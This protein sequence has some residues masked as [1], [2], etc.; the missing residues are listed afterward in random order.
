M[1][2]TIYT[3]KR[4]ETRK[5]IDSVFMENFRSFGEADLTVKEI[6]EKA[7]I[8][9]STF[10]AYYKD[11]A[12]MKEQIESRLID[13]IKQRIA[14]VYDRFPDRPEMIMLEIMAFNRENEFLPMLLISAGSSFVYRVGR[15]VAEIVTGTNVR[16]EEAREKIAMLFTYHFAGLS[17]VLRQMRETG[18]P[19]EE[20]YESMAQTVAETILPV[21]KN[22]LLPLIKDMYSDTDLS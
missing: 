15:T 8:N 1:G 13:Q 3:N 22:G 4:N 16:T 20:T 14:S 9:R 21:V 18:D 19:S 10:Y 17:M 11:T 7:E 12:D 6:C 2:K 5:R